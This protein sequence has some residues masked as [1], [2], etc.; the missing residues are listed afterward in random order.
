MDKELCFFLGAGASSAFGYP[1]TVEFLD[2]LEGAI[3]HYGFFE[4][5][6]DFIKKDNK[7]QPDIEK[8]IWQLE[9]MKE[10]LESGN[11]EK[12]FK[13]KYLLKSG[14]FKRLEKNQVRNSLNQEFTT[15]S[16][17]IDAIN[18][19]MKEQVYRTYWEEPEG[20]YEDYKKVYRELFKMCDNKKFDIFTTNYDISLDNLFLEN[21]DELHLYSDGFVGDLRSVRFENNFSNEIKYKVYKLHGSVNWRRNPNDSKK[22]SRL[23]HLAFTKLSDHPMLFPGSKYSDEYPFNVLYDHLKEKLDNG[24]YFIF[25]GFSFR[26]DDLNIIFK[27][28]LESNSKLRYIIW[29]PNKINTG[30]DKSRV[31][32]F[33]HNFGLDTLKTFFKWYHR[34]RNRRQTRLT[35]VEVFHPHDPHP[36]P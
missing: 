12:W 18:D 23:D 36:K 3:P 25:I 27:K 13:N 31:V 9:D 16:K 21:E 29:N 10:Y 26:D 24:E 30:F 20:E 6:V 28:A 5:I 33:E 8:V 22:I 11:E 19:K 32:Q 2:N 34:D 17:N 14:N 35:K 15:L 4:E 7:E 1:T